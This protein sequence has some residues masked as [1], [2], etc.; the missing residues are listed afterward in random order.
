MAPFV[1]GVCVAKYPAWFTVISQ[2]YMST[3]VLQLSAEEYL[4]RMEEKV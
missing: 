2:V 3:F 4:G 1:C